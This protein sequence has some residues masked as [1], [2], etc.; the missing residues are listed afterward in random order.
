MSDTVDKAEA[1]DAATKIPTAI[2]VALRDA[3]PH[4]QDDEPITP[5]KIKRIG[6]EWQDM[7]MNWAPFRTELT[8][9]DQDGETRKIEWLEGEPEVGMFSGYVIP[10]DADWCVSPNSDS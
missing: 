6:A 2:E 3:F 8:F 9:S 1:W 7:V 4:F 10:E 5:E